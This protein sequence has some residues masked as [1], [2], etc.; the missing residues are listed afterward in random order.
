MGYMRLT[1]H[2]EV[3]HVCINFRKKKYSLYLGKRTYQN[4]LFCMNQ[5]GAWNG[6]VWKQDVVKDKLYCRYRTQILSRYIVT[7]LIGLYMVFAVS[8]FMF[9]MQ[10]LEFCYKIIILHMILMIGIYNFVHLAVYRRFR[11]TLKRTITKC[12]PW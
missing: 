6:Y 2:M 5:P 4:L 9:G 12:F 3:I 7:V 1:C 11:F 10:F 8:I